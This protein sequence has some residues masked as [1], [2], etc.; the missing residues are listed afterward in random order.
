MNTARPKY[1]IPFLWRFFTRLRIKLIKARH[2]DLTV[3]RVRSEKISLDKLKID[4]AIVFLLTFTFM[5]FFSSKM[6]GATRAHNEELLSRYSL[7]S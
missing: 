5:M 2:A 7:Y 6:H 4:N 3:R 1:I